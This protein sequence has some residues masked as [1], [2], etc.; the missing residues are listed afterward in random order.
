MPD[1]AVAK[2]LR[3]GR[4][5]EEGIDFPIDEQIHWISRRM[6]DPLDI[7]V[8]IEAD[9]LCHEAHKVPWRCI[10]RGT[11]DRPVLQIENAASL[12][13][14]QRV[15]STRHAR[16][17]PLLQARRDPTRR[18]TAGAKSRVP[19]QLVVRHR[20]G[21]RLCVGSVRKRTSVNPSARSSCSATYCGARQVTG[22]FSN[23]IVVISGGGSAASDLAPPPNP[24][25]PTPPRPA[26][27]AAPRWPSKR[28]RLCTIG[29][30]PPMPIG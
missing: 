28:R 15:R 5:G 8:R 25:A 29:I 16:R 9:E 3:L 19:I 1:L 4:G 11:T 30:A 23:R 20:L 21:R 26:T 7:P 10:A 6:A 24:A 27:P 2:F 18:M 14:A 13:R 12:I 17:Q 22:A